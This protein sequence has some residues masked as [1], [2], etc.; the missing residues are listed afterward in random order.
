MPNDF[1][2]ELKIDG[3]GRIVPAGPLELKV[4]EEVTKIY[5]WVIQ[6]ND[7]GTSAMCSVV[8]DDFPEE[9]RWSARGDGYHAGRFHKGQALAMAVMTVR[10]Q[11]HQ[12]LG[13][14]P[15]DPTVYW[16]SETVVLKPAV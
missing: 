9:K 5:A 14:S 2:R 10:S 16:W 12:G 8:Q 3:E 13:G 1:D 7:D 4:G 15:D 11:S 6:A